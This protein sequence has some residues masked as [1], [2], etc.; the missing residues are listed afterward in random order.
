VNKICI[1]EIKKSLKQIRLKLLVPDVI[2][3]IISFILLTAF[4][5]YT[6]IT[7][8]TEEQISTVIVE[9]LT[10]FLGSMTVFLIVGFFIGARLKSFK[11]MM[12]L[13]AINSKKNEIVD[14]YKKSKKF[15]WKVIVLKL[16]SFLIL[17]GVFV[18]AMVVYSLIELI[19]PGF[20]LAVV[21][22]MFTILALALFFREAALFQK[23]IKPT[24]ALSNSFKIFKKHKLL[25]FIIMVIVF[26]INIGIAAISNL[27]S[28]EWLLPVYMFVVLLIS[29]WSYL[30]IFNTY[31]VLQKKNKPKKKAKTRKKT[32]RR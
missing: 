6:G 9:N 31:K 1:K 22:L 8:L 13:N 5:K 2:F 23:D 26:V 29:A 20:A 19:H 16:L 18:A 28:Q 27:L 4:T 10:Q 30:F 15:Y 32:K 11:L 3:L 7:G 17:L 12:I 21:I 14:S 24:E 25:V